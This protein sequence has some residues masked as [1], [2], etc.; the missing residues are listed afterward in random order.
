MLGMG[1]WVTENL[2]SESSNGHRFEMVIVDLLL[3]KNA[4]IAKTV[5]V[6]EMQL[7][8]MASSALQL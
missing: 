1:P 5:V 2:L 3:D 4:S 7:V 6:F 8:Q